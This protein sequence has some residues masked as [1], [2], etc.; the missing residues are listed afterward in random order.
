MSKLG[1][2][3]G[4]AG[5][6]RAVTDLETLPFAQRPIRVYTAPVVFQAPPQPLVTAAPS[7]R[8]TATEVTHRP[9]PGLARGEWEAPSWAFYG[10]LVVALFLAAVFIAQRLGVFKRARRDN[11]REKT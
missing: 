8:A 11:G 3:R 4:A 10:L 5:E 2:P 7:P 9:D 6:A 1:A